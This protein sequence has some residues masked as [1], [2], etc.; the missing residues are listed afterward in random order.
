MVLLHVK[1]KDDRQFLYEASGKES[2]DAILRE[3]VVV[4]NLQVRILSLKEEGKQLAIHG[5]FKAPRESDEDDSDD[6]EESAN[7]KPRGPF[8]CRDPSGHR[9]GEGSPK[10]I[11]QY[12]AK[13]NFF[14]QPLKLHTRKKTR[15]WC[16][17]VFCNLL[18]FYV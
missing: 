13:S 11:T 5:P 8:Y 1:Q 2:V 10:K 3:L 15:V 14:L 9:T 16:S 4:N 7:K 12:V 18:Y 6:D 17:S